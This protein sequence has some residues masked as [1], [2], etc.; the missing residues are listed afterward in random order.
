MRIEKMSLTNAAPVKNLQK[1]NLQHN[2][3]GF[4]FALI[5]PNNRQFLVQI[6]FVPVIGAEAL[7]TDTGS[8]YSI[9]LGTRVKA[10]QKESPAR[11]MRVE[12]RLVQRGNPNPN[13]L[14]RQT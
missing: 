3:E 4:L 12:A 10:F 5:N 14:N 7:L 1:G 13:L 9:Y 6:P 2:V 8:P 11:E